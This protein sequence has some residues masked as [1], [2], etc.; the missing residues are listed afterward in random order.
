MPL[1]CEY[2]R[3]SF[4]RMITYQG[5]VYCSAKHAAWDAGTTVWFVLQ[6]IGIDT[7]KEDYAPGRK[8]RY[9]RRRL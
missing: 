4:L 9:L 2:C 7:R 6:S 1:V 3:V 8:G 5:K